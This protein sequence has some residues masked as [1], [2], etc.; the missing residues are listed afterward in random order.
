MIVYFFNLFLDAGYVLVRFVLVE[1]QNPCHLDIQQLQNILLG[2]LTDKLRIERSQLFVNELA[3]GVCIFGLLELHFLINPF[4]NKDFLQRCE[5]KAFKQFSLVYFQFLAEQGQSVVRGFFK[6]GADCKEVGLFR[7]NDTAIGRYAYFAIGKC[8]ERI[9][10]FVRGYSRSKVHQDLYFFGS[11]ILYFPDLDFSLFAGLHNRVAYPGDGLSERHF[12]YGQCLVVYFIDF[13]TYLHHSTAFSIVVTGY[14]DRASRLEIRIEFEFLATQISN[15][16][17]TQ[18]IKVVRQDFG[19][20]P[21]SDTLYSLS[22]QER[23]FDR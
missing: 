23:E 13:G 16:G 8:I 12:G 21:H 9:Q 10:G 20:K 1:L 2:H 6:D 3:G 19:R 17:V 18:F 7:I 22:E 15:G 11:K 4:F 5:M 14:I